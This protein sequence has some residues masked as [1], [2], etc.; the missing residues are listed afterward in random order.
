MTQS[1]FMEKPNSD[2]IV[3]YKRT[4]YIKMLFLP[5]NFVIDNKLRYLLCGYADSSLRVGLGVC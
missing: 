5:Y 3:M 4:E 1:S 2:F